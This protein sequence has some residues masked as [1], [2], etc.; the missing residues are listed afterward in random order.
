MPI[1]QVKPAPEEAKPALQLEHVDVAAVGET[2]ADSVRELAFDGST[3]RI[4]LCVT[5]MEPLADAQ[6][7]R[8][9][10]RYT[11][12]RIVLST[13]AALE[14]SQKL[15]RVLTAMLKQGMAKA[16]EATA[17]GVKLGS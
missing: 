8:R 5:R 13:P 12:C 3:F 9:A 10:K 17:A 7:A 14:L 4:E 16:P 2:F 1:E 11:A 15:G 6:A